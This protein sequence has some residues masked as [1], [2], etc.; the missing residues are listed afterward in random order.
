MYNLEESKG[1]VAVKT[2]GN[3]FVGKQMHN[4]QYRQENK[5]RT[6]GARQ[7]LLHPNDGGRPPRQLF[8]PHDDTTPKKKVKMVAVLGIE[9]CTGGIVG[10]SPASLHNSQDVLVQDSRHH[11]RPKGGTRTRQATL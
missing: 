10:F 8:Q 5:S 2:A 3:V 1:R 9:R 7:M 11:K 4:G 6:N